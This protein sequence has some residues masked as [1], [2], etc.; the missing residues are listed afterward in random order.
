VFV[1]Q[2]PSEVDRDATVQALAERQIQSK[3]YLPAIHLMSYYRDRFGFELGAFPV[4][5]EVAKRSLALPFHPRLA[6]E[7]RVAEALRDALG[8]AGLARP[9]P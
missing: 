3:P 1:V 9:P 4:C 7:A 5:E 6:H 2:L 8:R